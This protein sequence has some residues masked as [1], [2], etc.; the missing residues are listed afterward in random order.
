M[1]VIGHNLVASVAASLFQQSA[2]QL[3]VQMPN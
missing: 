1:N 2:C 3:L